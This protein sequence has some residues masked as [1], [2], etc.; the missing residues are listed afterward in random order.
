MTV[1]ITKSKTFVFTFYSGHIMK[2]DIYSSR[3]FFN[4]LFQCISTRAYICA[5]LFRHTVFQKKNVC[6]FW[7]IINIVSSVYG[8]NFFLYQTDRDMIYN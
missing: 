3:I 7:K 8:S 6:L 4:I 5:T 1:F 2:L